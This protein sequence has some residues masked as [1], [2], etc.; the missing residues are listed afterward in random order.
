[1]EAT[2]SRK[3]LAPLMRDYLRSPQARLVAA[4]RTLG[5][6]AN[7]QDVKRLQDRINP[8]SESYS[9]IYWYRMPKKNGSSRPIC[10]LPPDLKA[11]HIMV[12]EVLK[13]T[14]CT[15]GTIYGVGEASRDELARDLK[16]LQNAGY[17]HLAKSD[18]IDC[19]QSVNPE[20]LYSLPLPKEVIRRALDT[21][22]P[23]FHQINYPGVSHASRVSLL[24]AGGS[25]HN[26]HNA[27]GPTGLMQGSPASNVIFALLGP[28]LPSNEVG[29]SMVCFDNIV[30]A[31]RS[32]DGC[33][34]MAITLAELFERCSAGPLALCDFEFADRSALDFLGYHFDPDRGDIGI[35][36]TSR[37]RFEARL[38]A[39][40]IADLETV[41]AMRGSYLEQIESGQGIV[42]ANPLLN[43][44]PADLWKTLRNFRAGF[45]AVQSNAPELEYY[46]ATTADN[47]L[48]RGQPRYE[49]LHRNLFADKNTSDGQAILGILKRTKNA[50]GC[51]N[52]R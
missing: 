16:H 24:S 1:M 5:G 44:P 51:N 25:Y 4:S 39:V 3:R 43:S 42:P 11:V 23:D 8:W 10:I 47:A 2:E 13:Q 14:I 22:N 12:K 20:A 34:A 26:Q 40:E 33:R 17:C 7:P 29:H 50:P 28:Q 41:W 48:M 45:S 36:E 30:I 19:F 52:A 31:A 37:A 18:V 9:P 35:A 46:L 21:R 6:Y 38:E 49:E 32:A 27:G 15:G